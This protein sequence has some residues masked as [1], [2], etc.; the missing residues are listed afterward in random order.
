LIST[1]QESDAGSGAALNKPRLIRLR[2]VMDRVGI[3][4]SMIYQRMS[5]GRFPK[6]RSLGPKCAV[7]VE[8]EIDEWVQQVATSTRSS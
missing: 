1:P 3:G 2:E 6:S 7:W 5:E 4:R 8:A